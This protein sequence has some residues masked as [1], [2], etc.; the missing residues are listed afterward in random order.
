MS[1]NNDYD[2]WR[3][4]FLTLTQLSTNQKLYVLKNHSSQGGDGV[5]VIS[6]SEDRDQRAK[7]AIN[8][9]KRKR[10]SS[11]SRSK[12]RPETLSW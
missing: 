6:L 3:K 2:T 1:G 9:G 5:K 11:Q 4:H 10:K 7:G 12:R 8:K